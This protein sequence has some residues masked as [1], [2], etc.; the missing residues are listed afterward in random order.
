M[1]KEYW[2]EHGD[3]CVPTRYKT[4]D[5]YALNEWVRSQ[6]EKRTAGTLTQEQID[7]LDAIGM[8]WLSPM[9]RFWETRFELCRAYYE[10]HGNL[11]MP[12]AYVT[13]DRVQLGLWL[14]RIRSG[15]VK[16][17]ASGENGN[18]IERLESIGFRWHKDRR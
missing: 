10:E 2:Q 12:A 8:D 3:L 18:Q 1:A 5:G 13:D 9:A 17:S 14:W 7:R 16:L 4:A 11:D 15:K 6:R